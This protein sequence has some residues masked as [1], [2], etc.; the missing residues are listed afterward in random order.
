MKWMLVD[1]LK[2]TPIRTSTR[3]NKIIGGKRV[4]GVEIIHTET[5][6]IER[7]AC[8]SI[9]F[10]GDW[11]P[12]N[13]IARNGRL[14]MNPHTNGPQADTDFRTSK[15]GVFAAG[16]VLR[17]VETADIAALE[18]R[19]AAGR[20]YEFLKNGRWP[21]QNVPIEVTP[22]I[23]WVFPNVVN[24][25]LPK[26]L[27]FRVTEFRKNGTIQVYQGNSKLHEQTF[28]RLSP[29]KS[30]QLNHDWISGIDLNNGAVT[31]VVKK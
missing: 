24:G 25:R 31:I 15:R 5:G 14:S 12:E 13:E 16:N 22:P 4:E 17:G 20:I 26:Q 1:L 3:V 29:N 2:R 21:E 30:M 8:D 27:T 7:V 18:G 23:E 11:I 28:G 19:T 6:K 10:T 9:I